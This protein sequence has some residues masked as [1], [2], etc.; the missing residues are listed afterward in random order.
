[1][2]KYLSRK[3]KLLSEYKEIA[4][5][6]NYFKVEPEEATKE[7]KAGWYKNNP[8]L[9]NKVLIGC[10]PRHPDYIGDSLMKIDIKWNFLRVFEIFS[11]ISELE[12]I[13]LGF[14]NG[15]VYFQTKEGVVDF[16]NYLK[17]T[18]TIYEFSLP[19][20]RK[21]VSERKKKQRK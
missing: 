6:M 2:K 21:I 12:G 13:T 5:F 8:F 4:S 7:I 19:I 16:E 10:P 14:K 20:V 11:K 15:K 9:E 17:L 3:D 1:M 18:E